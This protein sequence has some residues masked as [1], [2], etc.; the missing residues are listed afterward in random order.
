MMNTNR[1]RYLTAPQKSVYNGMAVRTYAE[2]IHSTK[3]VYEF[4]PIPLLSADQV[5]KVFFFEANSSGIA[6]VDQVYTSLTFVHQ[7]YRVAYTGLTWRLS[8]N[9]TG[10][11]SSFNLGDIALIPTVKNSTFIFAVKGSAG[12]P[13][14]SPLYLDQLLRTAENTSVTRTQQ[15]NPRWTKKFQ[16]GVQWTEVVRD[17][18]FGTTSAVTLYPAMKRFDWQDIWNYSNTT[19]IGDVYTNHI[20]FSPCAVLANWENVAASPY[21]LEYEVFVKVQFKGLRTT[22]NTPSE[23]W[24]GSELKVNT[25]GAIYGLR[26]GGIDG[27]EDP[28][29]KKAGRV[30]DL[31]D[32]KY[33]VEEYVDPH[34]PV[35]EEDE[36]MILAEHAAQKKRLE[37]AG[38]P[39][40][41][42]SFT[43]LN[44]GEVRAPTVGSKRTSEKV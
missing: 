30:P 35:D 27:K 29:L 1:A 33:G 5:Q 44:L 24:K 17:P 14:Y 18:Q 38:K 3:Y 31:S 42:R 21:T 20:I 8:Q 43:N 10:V 39:P 11:A 13:V 2:Y 12:S 32:V 28:G 26:T 7:Y 9:V 34:L 37:E 36:K 41:R 19:T 6:S 4:P 23:E 25:D 40:L 16:P 15:A 22:V